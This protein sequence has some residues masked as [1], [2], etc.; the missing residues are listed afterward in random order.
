MEK[1]IIP[2][3]VRE[4]LR[5]VGYEDDIIN[6]TEEERNA[7]DSILSSLTR[8]Q[9]IQSIDATEEEMKKLELDVK[10]AE[11]I[12]RLENNEDWKVFEEAYF[13]NEKDRLVTVLTSGDHVE[14]TIKEEVTEKL[15]AIGTLN[16][17]IK[18]KTADNLV[19]E[20]KLKL[21]T[22]ELDLANYTWELE[23]RHKK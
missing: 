12:K 10:V 8:E 21:A 19:K 15:L 13:T 20:A 11:A 14:K 6:Q 5:A 2:N 4:K 9:L 18:Y 7:E 17:F 22:Y 1:F 16:N 23:R 3:D